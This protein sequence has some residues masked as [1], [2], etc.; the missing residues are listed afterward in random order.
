MDGK[1]LADPRARGFKIPQN[2]LFTLQI[3]NMVERKLTSLE[4]PYFYSRDGLSPHPNTHFSP[5]NSGNC[6]IP[7]TEPLN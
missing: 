3:W 4:L 2:L 6:S 1:L 5:E 7:G